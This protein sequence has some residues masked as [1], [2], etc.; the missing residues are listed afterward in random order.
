MISG[1]PTISSSE[2]VQHL[3][4]HMGTHRKPQWL[5]E[6]ASALWEGRRQD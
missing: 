4:K 6:D 2:G 1:K 5:R 3:W